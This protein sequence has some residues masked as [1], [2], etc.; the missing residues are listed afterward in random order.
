MIDWKKGKE[1]ITNYAW[2][3]FR[4]TKKSLKIANVA[5]E[6]AGEYTCKGTNGFGTLEVKINLIVIG[7][8]HKLMKV[9]KSDII[10]SGWQWSL[11]VVILGKGW[12]KACSFLVNTI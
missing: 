8:L 1:T 4:A 11:L 10:Q 2:I 9:N 12:D 6:D 5:K 3:R 7:E